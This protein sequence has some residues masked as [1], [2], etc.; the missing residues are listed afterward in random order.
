MIM[1]V[2]RLRRLIFYQDLH[3]HRDPD[4]QAKITSQDERKRKR[5]KVGTCIEFNVS[6]LFFVYLPKLLRFYVK[7]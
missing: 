7:I 2:V 6:L 1:T 5:P 4:H 3:S